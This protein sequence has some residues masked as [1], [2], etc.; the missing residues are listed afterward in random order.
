MDRLELLQMNSNSVDLDPI[1]DRLENLGHHLRQQ[2]NQTREIA[3]EITPKLREGLDIGIAHK[4]HHLVESGEL[5][6][7]VIQHLQPLP[8]PHLNS[9]W[10]ETIVF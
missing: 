4:L 1:L 10:L 5:T 2:L 8:E 9:L 3:L 7:R 6:L